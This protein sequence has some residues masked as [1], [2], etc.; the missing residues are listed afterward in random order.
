[1]RLT[2][3]KGESGGSFPHLWISLVDVIKMRKIQKRKSNGRENE[4]KM[5]NEIGANKRKDVRW[6]R[7]GEKERK[8]K[9]GRK[10]GEERK[11]IG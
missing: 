7:K 11:E 10:Q 2:S 5:R 4:R 9:R 1:M 6:I 3:D 8:K